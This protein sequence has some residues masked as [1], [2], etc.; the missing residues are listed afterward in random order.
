MEMKIPTWYPNWT[1]KSVL[2]LFE[3]HAF[4]ERKAEER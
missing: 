4:Q 3:G 1:S 2:I